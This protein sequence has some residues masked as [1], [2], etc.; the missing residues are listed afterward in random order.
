MPPTVLRWNEP[1]WNV[2]CYACLGIVRHIACHPTEPISV[3]SPSDPQKGSKMGP[4]MVDFGVPNLQIWGL[5]SR[6][7]SQ[8]GPIWGT[9]L[10]PPPWVSTPEIP[11]SPCWDMAP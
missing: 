8:M 3:Y 1:L 4:K 2:P 7:G 10:D 11:R 6:N 5:G 9:I